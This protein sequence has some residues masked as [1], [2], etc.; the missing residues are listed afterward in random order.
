[1]EWNVIG[2]T[3]KI[4]NSKTET[5]RRG[6]CDL[7]TENN[8][9]KSNGILI[10]IVYKMKV[11][12]QSHCNYCNVRK[13]DWPLLRIGI[14]G[15]VCADAKCDA[16]NIEPLTNNGTA[17]VFNRV[18]TSK[19]RPKTPCGFCINL[20]WIL[21]VFNTHSTLKNKLGNCAQT[22]RNLI[23]NHLRHVAV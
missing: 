10:S 5:K 18:D 21:L 23:N 20:F 2:K 6:K 8:D 14:G 9:T 7:K 4:T 1:M 11:Q 13:A 3:T 12:R 17:S 22:H 16:I 15:A 19:K